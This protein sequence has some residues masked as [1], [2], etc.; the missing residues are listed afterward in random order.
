[1]LKFDLLDSGTAD[2]SEFIFEDFQLTH[3]QAIIGMVYQNKQADIS[4]DIRSPK[5][6]LIIIDGE[7]RRLERG[8]IPGYK[9][10]P[11][12]AGILLLSE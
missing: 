12:N 2:I 11:I 8:A 3:D 4:D 7:L 1:M 10:L 9:P 5:I 6:N